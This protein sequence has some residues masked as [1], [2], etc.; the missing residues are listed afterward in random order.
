MYKR[1][2]QVPALSAGGGVRLELALEGGSWRPSAW[3]LAQAQTPFEIRALEF[4]VTIQTVPV[5]LGVG[6]TAVRGESWRLDVGL[7]GGMD[8]FV[9]S[10]SSR[11]LPESRVKAQRVDV[12]GII[13]GTLALHVAIARSVD[14]WLALNVDVDP[15]RPRWVAQAGPGQSPVFAPWP[16]RPGLLLGFSFSPI[17]PDPYVAGI[18]AYR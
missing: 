18:G 14:V 17:G 16:V 9:T 7:G 15:A 2:A 13:T 11:T 8:V 6:V 10:P 3:L 1:Q 12:S 5:R 4:E